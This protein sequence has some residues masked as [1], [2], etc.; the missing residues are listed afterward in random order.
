MKTALVTAGQILFLCWLLIVA[1]A[2]VGA[3]FGV[4]IYSA[5][6]VLELLR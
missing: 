6:F 5:Q 2:A 3:L 1:W 4:A